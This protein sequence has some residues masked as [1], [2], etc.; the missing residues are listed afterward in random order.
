MVVLLVY[1]VRSKQSLHTKT[2]VADQNSHGLGRSS[3]NHTGYPGGQAHSHN[4][5][6][7]DRTLKVEKVHIMRFDYPVAW[8]G[9]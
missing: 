6:T 1:G 2:L 3:P 5:D 8:T 7:E 9:P 4:L